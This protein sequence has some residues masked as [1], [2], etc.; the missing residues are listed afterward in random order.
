[1]TKYFMEILVKTIEDDPSSE[2]VI[3]EIETLKLVIEEL[4]I[5]F[6]TENELSV[7]SEKV[8]KMLSAC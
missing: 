7:F 6:L 4:D 2:I 3:I 1:M 8:M 5:V